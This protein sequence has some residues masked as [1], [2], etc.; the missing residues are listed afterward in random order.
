[1]QKQRSSL[2]RPAYDQL[3]AWHARH[4]TS[5]VLLHSVATCCPATQLLQFTHARLA[6]L[7]VLAAL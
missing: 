7:S 5:S 4:V 3:L 6:Y 2:V 1:L